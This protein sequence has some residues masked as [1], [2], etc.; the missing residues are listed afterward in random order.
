MRID[1]PVRVTQQCTLRD[2]LC[3]WRLADNKDVVAHDLIPNLSLL[4][5]RQLF[6]RYRF[7]LLTE[8]AVSDI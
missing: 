7:T 5:Q 3:H 8:Y 6:R 2:G 4:F 1:F